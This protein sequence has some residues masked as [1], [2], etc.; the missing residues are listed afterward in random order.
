MI[1]GTSLREFAEHPDH[2]ASLHPRCFKPSQHTTASI[3]HAV[4]HWPGCPLRLLSFLSSVC[5]LL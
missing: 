4:S 3:D 1:A 2:W 5:N